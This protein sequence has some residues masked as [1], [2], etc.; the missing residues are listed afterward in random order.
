MYLYT[1]YMIK[2]MERISPN[3]L[4]E[5]VSIPTISINYVPFRLHSMLDYIYEKEIDIST[6][7]TKKIDRRKL[8]PS[9]PVY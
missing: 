4:L 2:S 3:F 1:V 9:M 5:N 8:T 6:V 7:F